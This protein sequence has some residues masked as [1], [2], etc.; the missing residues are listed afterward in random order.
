MGIFQLGSDY[1]MGPNRNIPSAHN[2]KKKFKYVCAISNSLTGGIQSA[3][4]KKNTFWLDIY[5]KQSARE[6][7]EEKQPLTLFHIK[8]IFIMISMS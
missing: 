7:K 2:I 1:N 4:C 6:R 5:L 3:T 8:F